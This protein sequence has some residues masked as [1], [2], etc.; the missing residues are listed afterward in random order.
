M[1]CSNLRV[2]GDMLQGKTCHDP[3]LPAIIAVSPDHLSSIHISSCS[4]LLM[5]CPHICWSSVVVDREPSL[6]DDG[7]IPMITHNILLLFKENSKHINKIEVVG[8]L[9]RFPVVSQ[10][11]WE[12]QEYRNYN[13]V[14]DWWEW[15]NPSCIVGKRSRFPYLLVICKVSTVSSG[16]VW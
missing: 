8:I 1:R 15:S 9:D 10:E 3:H 7:S 12:L 16:V 14:R 2:V 6:F 4:P 5:H 13:I 11:L